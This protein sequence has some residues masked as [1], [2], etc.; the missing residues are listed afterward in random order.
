MPN[1]EI[2]DISGGYNFNAAAHLISDNEARL[3]KNVSWR[4]GR[5]EK[6]SG[7][8]TPFDAA[9]DG[10][11]I[12]EI[13]D[14]IRND[15]TVHLIEATTDRIYRENS[16][17]LTEEHNSPTTLAT[18]EKWFFSEIFGKLF[19]ANGKDHVYSLDDPTSANFVQL[20]TSPRDITRASIVLGFH[21]RLMFF[22]TT[23]ASDG[24][25][26]YRVQWSEIADESDVQNANFL[27][28]DQ[29]NAPIISAAVFR[30]NAVVVYKTDSVWLVQDVGDPFY[31][32]SRFGKELGIIGP[33]ARATHPQ[34]DFFVSN[35]GFHLFVGNGVIDIGEGKYAYEHYRSR[36]NDAKIQNTYCWTDGRNKETH[37]MYPTGSNDEPDEEIVFNWTQSPFKFTIDTVGGYC[38]FNQYRTV[39]ESVTYHGSAAGVTKKRTGTTGSGEQDDGADITTEYQSKALRQTSPAQR[40][41]D[42][43]QVEV[44]DYIQ[45]N[46]I[47]ANLS[48]TGVS[49]ATARVGEAD[50]GDET[51][52]FSDTIEFVDTDG[53][54][55]AAYPKLV[56][57][58]GRFITIE[59]KDF[60]YLSS[61]DVE[62]EGAGLT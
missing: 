43:S 16:T 23:D 26:P 61:Y 5:W 42:G 6:R 50:T 39:D 49:G 47:L 24:E 33:K 9:G 34:G 13:V 7:Y 17:A 52:D 44:D 27:D 55:P 14:Y 4:N 45:I 57:S 18:T 1:V 58:T 22:N 20:M 59:L 21:S 37:I 48:P 28:L 25:R 10:N 30:T 32:Q 8:T 11:P 54:P 38:A 3:L 12:I 60:D 53:R 51:P 62:F 40:R 2:D 36:V 41:S 56:Q 19:A 15:G 29:S 46:Q 31:F 35:M